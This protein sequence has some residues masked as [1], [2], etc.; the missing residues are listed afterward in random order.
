MTKKFNWRA[1]TSLY[2]VISFLIMALSGLILFIAPPGRIANWTNLTIL[3]LTKSQ[4][5][6][7]HT[8]FTFLFILA[9][10]FHI[11]FNWRPLIAYLR[12]RVQQTTHIR[13][14][15]VGSGI[16]VTFL[17]FL[18]LMD[19][20]PVSNFME[21]SEDLSY[22]WSAGDTEPPI[23]H[24]E[25]LTIEQLAEQTGKSLDLIKSNFTEAG[26]ELKSTTITLGEMAS[27][28]H[29]SPQELY[30][31]I[32]RSKAPVNLTGGGYGRMTIRTLATKFDIP[33]EQCL[34]RLNLK[35]IEAS[36]D[37]IL[38]DLAD[39]ADMNPH[40]LLTILKDS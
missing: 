7:L 35:G 15:L 20:P 30:N 4:W 26:I 10:A 19:I 29:I 25:L 28:Q 37:D 21:F 1:F 22:A 23:P 9:A 2:I 36:P 31:M 32:T 6:A 27:A 34:Y 12:T 3:G 8:V 24:A 5:Q 39:Q 16:L 38:R 40:D 13:K 33:L 18:T 17:V 11:Y 14:E